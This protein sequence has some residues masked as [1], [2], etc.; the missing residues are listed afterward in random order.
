MQSALT[1]RID[2]VTSPFHQQLSKSPG[3]G[4][5]ADALTSLPVGRWDGSVGQLG[6]V[7]EAAK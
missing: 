2:V 1:A 5:W 6:G 3:R 4:F 7:K